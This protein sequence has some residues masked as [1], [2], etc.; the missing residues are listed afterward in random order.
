MNEFKMPHSP[1]HAAPPRHAVADAVFLFSHLAFVAAVILLATRY[2]HSPAVITLGITF[3]SIFFEALPFM[4]LGAL[5]G[6]CIEVFVSQEALARRLSPKRSQAIFLAAAAGLLLPVCECAIVPVVRRLLGKGLPLGA[7]VAFLLGAPI[8]NPL[9]FISTTVAYGGSSTIAIHR[10]LLGYGV[11]ATIGLV[12][13]R[14]FS[15]N[16]AVIPAPFEAESPAGHIVSTSRSARLIQALRHGSADFLDMGRF[17]V[18]GAFIAG[19]LQA[20]VAR[21]AFAAVAG[22]MPLSIAAMMILAVVL[23]LCSEADAFVAAA[24]RTTLPMTAQMAFMVLGPMLDMKLVLNALSVFR[25][26]AVAALAGFTV[27]AVFL[28]L[29]AYGWLTG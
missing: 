15:K 26:R 13:D 18:F 22:S 21:N 25:K 17:L 23:N 24:F 9:V 3:V 10:L 29:L 16:A 12:M 4:L 2:R 27:S 7:A 6:G 19:L 20:L 11:A 14:L 28:T 8:V 1:A 5:L